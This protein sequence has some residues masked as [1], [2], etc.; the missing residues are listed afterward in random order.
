MN[1][2]PKNTDQSHRVISSVVSSFQE[3]PKEGCSR[4][5]VGISNF[6]QEIPVTDFVNSG[7]IAAIIVRDWIYLVKQFDSDAQFQGTSHLPIVEGCEGDLRY[8]QW[9]RTRSHLDIESF[10][11]LPVSSLALWMLKYLF[12]VALDVQIKIWKSTDW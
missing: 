12:R 4:N 3:S 9:K 10:Q 7:N 5:N 2:G 8:V 1:N 11:A 6:C